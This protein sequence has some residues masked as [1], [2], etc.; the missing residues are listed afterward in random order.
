MQPLLNS[1]RSVF[2]RVLH[3]AFPDDGHAPAK[4]VKLFHMASVAIDIC[5]EFLPPK[6]FIGLGGGCVAATFMSV[7][8]AAVNE[9][10]RSA[11]WEHKVGRAWQFP[12]M[13]S[14]S[15]S[16][17]E[18]NGAERPFRPSVLSANA[19]HHAAAL[20]SGRDMHGLGSIPPRYLQKQQP[21]AYQ[22]IRTD[23]GSVRGNV[24]ELSMRLIHEKSQGRG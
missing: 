20:R 24:E 18:K 3:G 23:E 1:L 15:K 5:L 12:H 4:S 19:R 16:S 14:I 6:I 10:H 7:P 8:E 21:R 13:E 17:G 2:D 9:N 11:F 22:A